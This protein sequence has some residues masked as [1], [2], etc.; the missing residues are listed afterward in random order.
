MHKFLLDIPTSFETERLLLRAYQPGDGPWYLAMAQRNLT[1]LARYETD[2][3]A[4][5][6]VTE[7]DA[8]NLVRQF[9]AT[10]TARDAFFMGAFLTRTQEFVAQVYVG[11][12]SWDL[13][14]FEIG[15]FADVGHQ[16]NGYVTEAVKGALGFVFGPL[17][18]HRVRL[19]CDDTNLRS[20][21]VAER[22]GF[23]REGH[24][25]QN[26]QHADGSV[27][28]TLHFGLLPSELTSTT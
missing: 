18:A 20:L 19:E 27:S 9:A 13:P 7:D 5:S 28:G 1:H 24:I 26:H 10:W 8:E 4:R 11:V 14:E 3:P 25:R 16:G 21:R 15:Y 22:C 17:G 2:N 12:S 23:V 6:L